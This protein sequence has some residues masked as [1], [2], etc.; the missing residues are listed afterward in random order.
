M[1]NYHLSL[2]LNTAQVFTV[3]IIEQMQT[4]TGQQADKRDDYTKCTY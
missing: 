4:N 2:T 3:N 1:I